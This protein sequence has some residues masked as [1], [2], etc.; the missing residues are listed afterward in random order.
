[1]NLYKLIPNEEGK[2]HYIAVKAL[3][4]YG[5]IYMDID[6]VCMKPFDELA[7]KYSYFSGVEPALP[8][9]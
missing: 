1:M 2:Q 7:Y 9:S 4:K 5:G 8:W 6:Y 3:Q